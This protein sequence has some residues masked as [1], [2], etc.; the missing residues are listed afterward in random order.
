MLKP[1]EIV[2]LYNLIYNIVTYK[3]IKII[4]ILL[5]DQLLRSKSLSNKN[6]YHYIINSK[7][8]IMTSPNSINKTNSTLTFI[9]QTKR[10]NPKFSLNL[11]KKNRI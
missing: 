8:K 10:K 2:I 6:I 7:K 4:K 1:Q 9:I 5:T 3:D 11:V